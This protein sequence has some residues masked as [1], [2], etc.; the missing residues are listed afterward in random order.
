MVITEFIEKLF[1][2]LQTHLV[3]SSKIPWTVVLQAPIF[4]HL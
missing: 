3:L 1:I 2:S 4:H